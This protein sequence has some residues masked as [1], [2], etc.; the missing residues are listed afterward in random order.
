M[1][2]ELPKSN[3]N[4][5]KEFLKD[6]LLELGLDARVA[7]HFNKFFTNVASNLFSKL[8]TSTNRFTT[9]SSIFKECCV[10]KGVVPGFLKIIYSY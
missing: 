2:A 10:N 5:L 4:I 1:G 9:D 3:T 7:D 8:P 6:S